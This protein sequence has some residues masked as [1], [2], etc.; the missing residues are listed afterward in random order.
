MQQGDLVVHCWD[1]R[2]DQSGVVLGVERDHIPYTKNE[3][4]TY[5]QVRWVLSSAEAQR[6]FFP[7]IARHRA[8]DLEVISESR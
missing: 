5:V 1:S 2:Y 3:F 6:G 7:L 4:R 8:C